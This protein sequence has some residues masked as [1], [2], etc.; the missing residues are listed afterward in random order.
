MELK[1]DV[2]SMDGKRRILIINFFNCTQVSSRKKHRKAGRIQE[3]FLRCSGLKPESGD[4]SAIHPNKDSWEAALLPGFLCFIL[5]TSW[6]K[7]REITIEIL[8]FLVR[9]RLGLGSHLGFRNRE[10]RIE[11][12]KDRK[13]EARS[14]YYKRASYL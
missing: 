5:D 3:A 11:R 7:S 9:L 4:G 2:F 8:F 1:G 13:M 14:S 12:C 10:G 6:V